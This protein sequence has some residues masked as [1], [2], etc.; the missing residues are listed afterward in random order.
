MGEKE[1]DLT[2]EETR[3][4]SLFDILKIDK[5]DRF[6]VMRL[7]RLIDIPAKRLN[8]YQST[9]KMPSGGDLEKICKA[10]GL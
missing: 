6:S 2:S 9:N 1:L 7:A 4:N 5:K 10:T 8:Y 3:I